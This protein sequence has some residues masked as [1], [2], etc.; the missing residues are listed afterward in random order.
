ML[1][2]AGILLVL[3]SYQCKTT[4]GVVYWCS[5]SKHGRVLNLSHSSIPAELPEHELLSHEVGQQLETGLGLQGWWSV[6]G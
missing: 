4:A 6:V 1:V 3:C 5:V 2:D